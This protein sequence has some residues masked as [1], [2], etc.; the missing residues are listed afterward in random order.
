[1]DSTVKE[2]AL[3]LWGCD[4]SCTHLALPSHSLGDLGASLMFKSLKALPF[5]K[6][7]DLSGNRLGKH[8]LTCLSSLLKENGMVES[9][10]LSH[11]RISNQIVGILVD[12]FSTMKALKDVNLSYNRIGPEGAAKLASFVSKHETL[13]S[14]ML[15]GNMLGADGTSAL[16]L[17]LSKTKSLSALYLDENGLKSEGV[18]K[19]VPHLEN[20]PSLMTLCLR[21][22]S[23]GA[24]AIRQ[25]THALSSSKL[26]AA[27]SKT[28]SLSAL[29]LD[30]N[31]LKSEGVLK[32]VPHLE[33]CPSL[34]TLCLRTNSIGADAI[35]QLTHALSS[36]K[37]RALHLDGNRFG[38]DAADGLASFI[39]KSKAIKK[40]SLRDANL[41]PAGIK[42]ILQALAEN[43]SLLE[44]DVRGNQC[45]DDIADAFALC[46][47][48]N[49]T[50]VHF[51]L[52]TNRI[53]SVFRHIEV[54]NALCMNTTL[55]TILFR[56]NRMD[57]ASLTSISK[58]LELTS[59]L[60]E[61]DFSCGRLRAKG[62]S[63]LCR[64]LEKNKT[65]HTI[66]L[67]RCELGDDGA[68]QIM[69]C[70]MKHPSLQNIDLTRNSITASGAE[71]IALFLEANE[72]IRT[73][74]LRM[75]ILGP[76]GAKRLSKSLEKNKS[77]RKIDLRSNGIGSKG[78]G[79]LVKLLLRNRLIEE[80]LVESD[81]VHPDLSERLRCLLAINAAGNSALDSTL[82]VAKR[83]D[84]ES[85]DALFK[86]ISEERMKK[87]SKKAP[88]EP[89]G[90][91]QTARSG[92][93]PP[94]C[95]SS[96]MG[97]KGT[98]TY[99]KDMLN[100]KELEEVRM[101][102][103]GATGRVFLSELWKIPVAV[104]ELTITDP[105]GHPDEFFQEVSILSGLNHPNIVSLHG[106]SENSKGMPSIIME[107]VDGRSLHDMIFTEFV[108][109]GTTFPLHLTVDF[110]YKIALA[111]HYLHS[112]GILHRDLKPQ[113]VLVSHDMHDV[114]LCDFGY[115][116]DTGASQHTSTG[117]VGTLAYMSPETAREERPNLD[118][119]DVWSFGMCIFEMM[120]GSL[121]FEGM[122]SLKVIKL[123]AEG[124][125]APIPK[126]A[127]I[128]PGIEE[129]FEMCCASNAKDRPS[130][131]K[132]ID[133]LRMLGDICSPWKSPSSVLKKL[134]RHAICLGPQAWSTRP[135]TSKQYA[136]TPLL[137]SISSMMRRCDCLNGECVRSIRVLRTTVWEDEFER[138]LLIVRKRA[139]DIQ[140]GEVRIAED[141]RKD[142]REVRRKLQMNSFKMLQDFLEKHLPM[143]G[144]EPHLTS[145]V[146]IPMLQSEAE[147]LCISGIEGAGLTD[148]YFFE[149]RISTSVDCDYSY[150]VYGKEFVQPRASKKDPMV[151]L[152]CFAS[153]AN[154]YP[155]VDA[156]RSRSAFL[157]AVMEHPTVPGYD[158]YFAYVSKSVTK[159][160]FEPT[161]TTE[162]GFF[163]LVLAPG[164]LLLPVFI[165]EVF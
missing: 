7:I 25:L 96:K 88:R 156:A 53:R 27:L 107:Y 80:I 124:N 146:S 37:L 26:R 79:E 48:K 125:H 134:D 100:G 138:R 36:S 99:L 97:K 62:A 98:R 110:S 106:A 33:N 145:L 129:L 83:D 157:S 70:L 112:H 82:A 160:M 103:A 118:E 78:L 40:L 139:F 51:D 115:A 136:F 74:I 140:N 44:L 119:S 55:E 86:F 102:G 155:V 2:Y 147:R 162:D 163:E 90:R 109:R 67:M 1:M 137:A 49:T 72:T 16:G 149:G 57:L 116:K 43:A 6:I 95:A 31:G 8:A 12:A 154:V 9:V 104:K 117:I 66:N 56:T 143:N 113:N 54:S 76:R 161:S 4:P 151:L 11:N 46:F 14:L 114:R 65:L 34:M 111:L 120:T 142:D 85:I 18:L 81:F 29:Y 127:H 150:L 93:T 32:L 101:V 52:G 135:I 30:E 87:P 141:W 144:F 91:A 38:S 122:T 13:Q 131:D 92:L 84:T 50:L 39:E 63:A 153:L 165:L 28:K 58:V 24:D 10:Q 89:R 126:K 152:L 164:T 68:N 61:I 3:Q 41:G 94:P 133:I 121:P 60:R 73:L 19:L 158:G 105:S 42:A 59:C 75:N 132:I 20:C 69:Q 15:S 130:F 23:I 47:K 159:G 71:S 5:V 77:L 148:S 17:A 35:R 21:T 108:D 128:F 22:N 123:L 45:G 64:G